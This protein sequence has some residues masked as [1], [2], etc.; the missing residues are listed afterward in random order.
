MKTRAYQGTT[1]AKQILEEQRWSNNYPLVRA[2]VVANNDPKE[3]GRIQVRIMSIH[4]T[5]DDGKKDE[6]LPWASPCMFNASYNSGS[7][8][9]PEV[10]NTVWVMF[11]DGDVNKP[12][13]MGGMYGTGVT[14]GRVVGNTDGDMRYQQMYKNEKP[15]E[16]VSLDDKV[17]YRSPKGAS[18]VISEKKGEEKLVIKDQLGQTITMEAPFKDIEMAAFEQLSKEEKAK[19]TARVVIKSLNDSEI[20]LESDLQTSK[21]NIA[22]KGSNSVKVSLDTSSGVVS[23]KRD[24]VEMRLA[25]TAE[26]R[27]GASAVKVTGGNIDL[28]AP[29]VHINAE[30][31]YLG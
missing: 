12:V 26:L 10:G 21:L 4:G 5:N 3:V 13:Y 9:I 7:F 24:D 28:S 17:I 19:G 22:L 16:V 31:V 18:V 15:D 30:D 23:V 8:I 11:E 14:R 2:K 27:N 25:E 6:D 20:E 1:D 29:I